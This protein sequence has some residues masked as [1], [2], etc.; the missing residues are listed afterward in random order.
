V[1]GFIKQSGGAIGIKSEVGR[2]T[3]VTLYLPRSD[4][5]VELAAAPGTGTLLTGNERILVVEDEPQVRE[6]VARQ[7]R[8]LGYEVAEAADGAAGLAAF[9]AAKAPYDLLLT[10]IV[11]PGPLSGNALA[12][13]VRRRWPGTAVAF[14]S[15]YS[16]GTRASTRLTKPFR[17]HELARYVREALDSAM[18]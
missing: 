8:S 13:Q 16:E 17:K 7:L 6:D 9:E 15:G 5:T 10:D 2:G 3:T 11:M 1:Y 4:K 12:E 14:M 18:N